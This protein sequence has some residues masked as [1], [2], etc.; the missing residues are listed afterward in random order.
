MRTYCL[1]GQKAADGARGRLFNVLRHGADCQPLKELYQA[2]NAHRQLLDLAPSSAATATA[3]FHAGTAAGAGFGTGFGAGLG[4]GLSAAMGKQSH[5]GTAAAAV[6]TAA[7]PLRGP[8]FKWAAAEQALR[9]MQLV[10]QASPHVR[11]PRRLWVCMR[12]P[13]R[14]LLP[15]TPS[16]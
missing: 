8:D 7:Q 2:T 10:V 5:G 6:A 14:C 13:A 11:S 12:C 1:L 15:P 16:P 9:V 3:A 4:G